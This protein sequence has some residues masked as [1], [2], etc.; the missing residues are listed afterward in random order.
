MVYN[1]L[2]DYHKVVNCTSF[3]FNV[4][5]LGMFLNSSRYTFIL[6]PLSVDFE[7]STWAQC[8]R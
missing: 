8:H 3:N 4:K 1:Q 5:S 2:D 6:E 7:P